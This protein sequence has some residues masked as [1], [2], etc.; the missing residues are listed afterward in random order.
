MPKIDLDDVPVRTGSIYP[1]EFAGRVAGRSSLRLGP[2]GGLTQFGVNIVRL[3]PGVAA[4]LRHWHEKEDE[5]LIVLTGELVL[6][7]NEGETI[8]RPG[9]CAAFPANA[10]NGHHMVNRTQDE[11][12][13]LVVGTS[14]ADETAHY[15]DDDL[16]LRRT[17]E[18][19]DFMRAD[20]S[21]YVPPAGKD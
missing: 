8:M 18:G 21:P 17:P 15:P 13:F 16:M 10:P 12:R 9:D 2:A 11:A 14:F 4:S 5:F 7:E 1:A 20:A 3:P 6:I 19:A